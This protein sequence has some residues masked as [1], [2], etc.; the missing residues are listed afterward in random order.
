MIDTCLL[1]YSY[2]KQVWILTNAG[3][4]RM[5]NGFCAVVVEA[6]L[7]AVGNA[8]TWLIVLPPP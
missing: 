4:G 7:V 5:R 8:L 2:S 6:E 1:T 3:L